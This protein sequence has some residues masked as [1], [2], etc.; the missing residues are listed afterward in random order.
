MKTPLIDIV[1]GARYW[2]EARLCASASGVEICITPPTVC[3]AAVSIQD[4]G[5][6]IASVGA[7]EHGGLLLYEWLVTNQS[8][9][10]TVRHAAVELLMI[11]GRHYAAAVGKKPVMIIDGRGAGIRAMAARLGFAR[12][13]SA[14]EVLEGDDHAR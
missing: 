6:Y 1:H 9:P 10:A 3:V 7:V 14:L 12:L 2:Q 13:N 5:A 8:V 11:A 4:R